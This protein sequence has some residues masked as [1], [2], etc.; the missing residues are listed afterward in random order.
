MHGEVPFCS[1]PR[2]V[3]GPGGCGHGELSEAF[4][5]GVGA[6]WTVG[7]AAPPPPPS[8]SLR[9]FYLERSNLP[10]DASTTAVKIDQVYPCFP[11][12]TAE[13]GQGWGLSGHNPE[14][15]PRVAPQ[16]DLA[17]QPQA[18]AVPP[19]RNLLG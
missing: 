18:S 19:P 7:M 16:P 4:S 5:V 17:E 11:L 15:R 14:C 13:P 12:P 9:A 8:F 1:P 3:G 10:T 6:A 2:A